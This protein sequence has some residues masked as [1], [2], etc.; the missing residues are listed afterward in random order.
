[1]LK[2]QTL[3]INKL[4]G[5]II[6]NDNITK[7][8]CDNQHFISVVGK[9]NGYDWREV[10]FEEW[11]SYCHHRGCTWNMKSKSPTPPLLPSLHKAL[12]VLHGCFKQH[13]YAN[14]QKQLC[15]NSCILYLVLRYQKGA[16]IDSIW[17]FNLLYKSSS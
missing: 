9:W 2:I 4:C 1:M 13:M 17:K 7:H 6:M 14:I 16:S 10:C 3:T 12:I 15:F 11:T 8:N 5:G